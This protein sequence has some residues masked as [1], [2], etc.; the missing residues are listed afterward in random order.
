MVALRPAA[1][2]L[3]DLDRHRPADDVARRQ[4]LGVRRV[5]LHEALAL[6]VGHIAALAAR[7][8][9]DQAA[10]A[11]N[12]GRVEL[13]ELHVLQRQPGA[14]HHRI[15]VAGAGVGRGAG[16]I[17]PAISAG[18]ENHDMSAKPMQ[19]AVFEVPR[20]DPAADAF[21]VHDQV[22]RKV[23][24]EEFGVMAHALLVERMD[25]R[26]PGSVGGGAGAPGRIAFAVVPHMAA[27]R[28]LVDPPVLGARERHAEMFEL[29]D[30][31]D[32]IA[33][34]VFDRVLVA[35]PVGA[36]DR[37]VHVPAPVV[38]AHIAE[39]G[40]DA[41]LRGDG[42]AAGRE[43]LADAG[44]LQPFGGRPKGRTQSRRRR[45]RRRRCHSCDR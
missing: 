30:G 25:D 32:R 23:L 42:V 44:G 6:A 36:L 15:A 14:Q 27:E 20:H 35:E 12:S 31:R 40:A 33:A 18:G 29:D 45:R 8:L 28:P 7:P 3:A 10:G 22:E 24:D 26:V 11:V 2:A 13:D 19:S 38:L 5:A 17:R 4:V 21:I 16:E 9:G 39:C 1:A 41:A 34:H 37:V 43:H